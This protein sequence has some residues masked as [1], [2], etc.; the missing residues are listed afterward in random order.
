MITNIP[1]QQLSISPKN[2]RQVTTTKAA[3]QQLI[4]SI[5]S[6]GVLQNLVVEPVGND[7]FQVIAGGRRFAA[8]GH[9]ID[10]EELD[11]DFLIPCLVKS[12]TD[13]HIEISLAENTQREAMHP[14][15]RFFGI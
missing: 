13:E 4:A 2:V 5:R 14:A 12:N 11:S 1:F 8:V 10:G 7:Q 15:D 9:L 6:Q 3:D